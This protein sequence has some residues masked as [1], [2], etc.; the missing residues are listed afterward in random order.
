MTMMSDEHVKDHFMDADLIL[1]D[2]LTALPDMNDVPEGYHNTLGALRRAVQ[3]AQDAA[4]D[5]WDHADRS[6]D[7]S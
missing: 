1:Q 3:E 4:S 7:L 6:S 2:L 5:A